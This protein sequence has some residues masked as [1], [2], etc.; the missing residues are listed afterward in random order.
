MQMNLDVVLLQSTATS[1]FPSGPQEPLRAD[2]SFM[3]A[4]AAN[5]ARTGHAELQPQ[6]A[7]GGRASHFGYENLMFFP[8]IFPGVSH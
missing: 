3:S 5:S 4:R 2:G 1:E 6:A 7:S 8:M